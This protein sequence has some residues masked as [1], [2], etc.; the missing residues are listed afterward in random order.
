M[1][2]NAVEIEPLAKPARASMSFR[3]KLTVLAVSLALIPV[4]I[5]GLVSMDGRRQTGGRLAKQGLF[6]SGACAAG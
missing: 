1:S 4:A 2:D 6:R 5:V 3:L